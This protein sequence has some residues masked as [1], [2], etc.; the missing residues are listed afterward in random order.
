MTTVNI[1][2][3]TLAGCLEKV[4]HERV[5]LTR[6]GK[7]VALLVNV[8]GLDAEQIEL[9]SNDKFWRMIAERRTQMTLGREQLE[10]QLDDE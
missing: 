10:Q 2:Q 1:E 4:Q 9:G 7:P 6:N 5:I 8:E 3:A